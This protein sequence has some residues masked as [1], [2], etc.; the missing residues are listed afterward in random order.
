MAIFR[1]VSGCRAAPIFSSVGVL[2]QVRT[3]PGALLGARSFPS[4]LF[5]EH[6][7]GRRRRKLSWP[8][9]EKPCA[10]SPSLVRERRETGIRLRHPECVATADDRCTSGTVK[11][12]GG[13]HLAQASEANMTAAEERRCVVPSADGAS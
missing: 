8:D 10:R 12:T 11:A 9:S 3:P 2:A 1:A 13:G 4:P 5:S 6:A 7:Q